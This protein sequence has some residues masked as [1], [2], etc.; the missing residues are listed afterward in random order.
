MNEDG[1]RRVRGGREARARSRVGL[2]TPA[3]IER[4]IPPYELLGEE[5]LAALEAHAD[6]ILAEIGFEIPR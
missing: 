3:F 6:R 4:R 1:G 2:A 5:G